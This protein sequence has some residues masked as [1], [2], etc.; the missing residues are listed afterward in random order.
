MCESQ[1]GRPSEGRSFCRNLRVCDRVVWE[2]VGSLNRVPEGCRE[3]EKPHK[4]GQIPRHPVPNLQSGTCS[5][6]DFQ[7][8]V[9]VC[10]FA[11][12]HSPAGSRWSGWSQTGGRKNTVEAAVGEGMR[13]ALQGVPAETR[14][15]N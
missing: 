15:D 11:I 4:A 2:R 3:R 7:Q 1:M 9:N 8:D 6:E 14:E 10:R 13:T 5:L 12:G